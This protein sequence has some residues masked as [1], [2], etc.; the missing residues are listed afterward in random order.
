MFM[1]AAGFGALAAASA[2][3]PFLPLSAIV[4]LLPL[5]EA[6]VTLLWLLRNR[7]WLED[8]TLVLRT[9]Y[10]TRRCDLS[11]APVW[12]GDYFGQPRLI[13]LDD[14][15]G[16]AARLRY[17]K[18]TAPELDAVAGAIMARGR[19]DHAAWQVVGALQQRAAQRQR[20]RVAPAGVRDVPS[21]GWSV[22]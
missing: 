5:L 14:S 10:A 18:L 3:T 13:A 2:G 16:R 7:A 4:A 6:F 17:N 9:S 20:G 22:R 12:L 21:S 1:I 8:T 19:Q 11:T 15:G